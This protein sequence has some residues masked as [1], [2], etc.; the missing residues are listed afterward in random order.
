MN[1]GLQLEGLKVESVEE[2]ELIYDS[3][4]T[5]NIKY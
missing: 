2:F 3:K 1:E 4:L 5:Y